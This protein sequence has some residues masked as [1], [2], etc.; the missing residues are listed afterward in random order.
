MTQDQQQTA[1]LEAQAAAGLQRRG[2]TV[3]VAE[4]CTGGLLGARLTAAGGS[5]EYFLG[6]IVAYAQDVKRDVLGVDAALL[7]AHGAVSA[8]VAEDMARKVRLRLHSDVGISITGIAGP[9]GGTAQKPVGLVFVGLATPDG[10]HARRCVF[11][12]DRESVRCQSV[13]TA[14]HEL[15]ACMKKQGVHHG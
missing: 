2:W 13:E 11:E 5:S 8:P 9:G 3:A 4:S 6:G 7:E 15:C 1:G 14:L 12:G 10:V